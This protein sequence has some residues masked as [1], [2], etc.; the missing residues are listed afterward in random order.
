MPDGAV[1]LT[2]G[3]VP[4]RT[5]CCTNYDKTASVP[6]KF[7]TVAWESLSEMTAQAGYARPKFFLKAAARNYAYMAE[8]YANGGKLILENPTGA[9]SVCVINDVF[10]KLTRK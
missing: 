6:L 2:I 8:T 5:P 10:G 1:P 9:R 4:D 7:G 3:D